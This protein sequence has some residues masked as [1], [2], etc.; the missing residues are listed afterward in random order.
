MVDQNKIILMSKIAVY[1]KRYLQK[2]QKITDY[3]V[4]DYVYINNFI[5]RLGISLIIIGFIGMGALKIVCKEIVYIKAYIGPWIGML[6]LYTL[7][8]TITYGIRYKR[9]SKRFSQYKKL[10]RELNKYEN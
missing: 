10:I 6:I 3:F 9:A 5:T 7:I 2:D 8:S 4:E 1:E